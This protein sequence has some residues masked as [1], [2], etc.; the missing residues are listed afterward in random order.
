M[1]CSGGILKCVDVWGIQECGCGVFR[2][3][4]QECGCV[5][6]RW[7]IQECGCGVLQWGIQKCGC[8]V[9][10][11]GTDAYSRTS[12]CGSAYVMCMSVHICVCMHACTCESI[13]NIVCACVCVCVHARTCKSIYNIVCACIYVC[14]CTHAHANQYT[15]LFVH[16]YMCVCTHAHE[17]QY[18]ILFVRAHMCVCA[19][20]H[21]QINKQYCLCVG[22]CVCVHT[23]TC[24]SIYNTVTILVDVEVE[25]GVV[26]VVGD[27]RQVERE[28]VASTQELLHLAAVVQLEQRAHAPHQREHVQVLVVAQ[29]DLVALL[30]LLHWDQTRQQLRAL[31]QQRGNP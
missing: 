20:M 19:R 5:V 8:G 30:V 14:V 4:I 26:C 6:L 10:R 22:I 23:C 21:M 25:H 29:A 3:G 24:E 15:I 13:Y 7:G 27:V 2:W 12:N 17:N 11:W 16:V 31:R 28:V 9:F 18:T 1:G